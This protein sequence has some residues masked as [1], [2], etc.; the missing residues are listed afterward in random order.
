[1]ETPD[2]SA[3]KHALRQSVLA[4]VAVLSAAERAAASAQARARLAAQPLWHDAQTV[5]FYAPMARELDVWPLLVE[6]LAQ[7]KTVGLPRFEAAAQTYSLCEVRDLQRDLR[8]GR[9]GI[10]E[11]GPGC[12]FLRKPLDVL[13]VPGVAYDVRGRRLGRGKGYYDRIL[14]GVSGTTCGVA[15]DCQIVD[16]VPVDPHDASVNCILTPGRWHLV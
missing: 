10:R 16:A 13:L 11:P 8:A 6:A 12:A 14:A 5:L 3:A 9:Y 7:G 15:F 4:A 2:I 1:M